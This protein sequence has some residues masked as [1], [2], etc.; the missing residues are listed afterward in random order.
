MR[1]PLQQALTALALAVAAV[2]AS[3]QEFPNKP[4]RVVIPYAAGGST[5]ILT[6]QMSQ[7]LTA[8]L[9]QSVIVEN[10]AGANGIIGTEAVAKAAPDG[11]TLLMV[12]NGQT[13]SMGLYPKLPWDLEKDFLPVVNVATMPNVIVVHPSQPFQ[14]LKD[15][16]DAVRARPGALS[17]AHAGVGS[18]QHIAGELFKLVTKARIEQIPYK[19]GGPAIADVVAGQ[20]PV[21]VGGLPVVRQH[22]GNGRLRA[23]ALTSSAR[24]ALMPDIPTVAETGFP[25]FDAIFWIGLL[26]PKGTPESVIA[27]VNSD[28]NT[29]LK[30]P[31]IAASFAVQGA[32]PAGGTAAAFGAWIRQ[33]I[34]TST[35]VIREANIKPEG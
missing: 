22:I 31:D 14:T 10:R 9:G 15:L 3:A 34:E 26:A 16:L 4:V 29:V 6:R 30:D 28:V 33:D 32:T 19:G 7:K 13:I 17:Y 25:P 21:G 2:G 24:S 1:R 11:Y 35:R 8:R 27:R 5:D 12:T 20:V 18:P 23:L